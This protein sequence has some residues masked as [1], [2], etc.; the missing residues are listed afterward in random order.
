M[1]YM[2]TL[3]K[4]VEGAGQW[5]WSRHNVYSSKVLIQ[6]HN[7]IAEWGIIF[8][9]TMIW[10]EY[11]MISV[12]IN[13]NLSLILTRFEIIFKFFQNIGIDK[14]NYFYCL[15]LFSH[16]IYFLRFLKVDKNILY[17]NLSLIFWLNEHI[18]SRFSSCME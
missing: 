15:K 2:A 11:L 18:K 9:F 13:E 4:Y 5:Q 12:L 14:L 6:F 16:K 3:Q 10:Y 8:I 17:R 7:T 1:F